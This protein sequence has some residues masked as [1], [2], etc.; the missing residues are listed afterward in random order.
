MRLYL[1]IWHYKGDS[2]PLYPLPKGYYPFGNPAL[3]N[4]NPNKGFEF[5]RTEP[6]ESINTFS[7][8]IKGNKI[9]LYI[10]INKYCRIESIGYKRGKFYEG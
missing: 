2:V 10:Q 3:I 4:S 1:L 9:P 7:R 6:P 5:I 8:N